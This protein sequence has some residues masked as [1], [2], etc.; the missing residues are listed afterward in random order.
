MEFLCP[1]CQN[2]LM[3][4]DQYA[5]TLMKC[6][7]C[8]KTFQ[9]P[10]AAPALPPVPPPAASPPPV[11]MGYGL[12]ADSAAP[13]PKSPPPPPPSVAPVSKE[14]AKKPVSVPPTSTEHQHTHALTLSPKVLPWV[15]VGAWVVVFI[16]FWF[17]WVGL[18]PG[19]LGVFTQGPLSASVGGGWVDLDWLAYVKKASEDGNTVSRFILVESK[20]DPSKLEMASLDSSI[21][22]GL[23]VFFFFWVALLTAIVS[24]VWPLVQIRLPPALEQLR[25]WR[26]A[27]AAG[28]SLLAFLLL[29]MQLLVGFSLEHK[30][31]A[32]AEKKVNEKFGGEQGSFK[33]RAIAER[34]AAVSPQRTLALWAAFWLS[35]L[36]AA[37]A[38][39]Q[40]WLDY[41]GQ[42]PL[43]QLA[44]R[45]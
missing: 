23:F 26:W 32:E 34:E 42:R 36:A 13:P 39:L 11:T 3:V 43:P 28:L 30:V 25:P 10:A 14:P 17:P 35:L 22:L 16:L 6:P 2:K 38:V 7:Y 41:R 31:T 18:Y 12:A 15:S 20:A 5:G 8:S 21:F 29:T 1:H 45:W 4:Q 24:A 27:I 44:V 33:E 9:A 37:A 40:F 19:G